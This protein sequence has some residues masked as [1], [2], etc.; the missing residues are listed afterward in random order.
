MKNIKNIIA[1]AEFFGEEITEQEATERLAQYPVDAIRYTVEID[2]FS[3]VAENKGEY[4][5]EMDNLNSTDLERF[6][7]L[8]IAARIIAGEGENSITPF[9]KAN[10]NEPKSGEKK[11]SV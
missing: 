6:L 3:F 9:E 4:V 1:I 10:P 7:G 2:R 8:D 5:L 11:L